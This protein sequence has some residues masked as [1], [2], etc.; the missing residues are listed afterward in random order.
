MSKGQSDDLSERELE[1]LRL[2]ATGA[3]N[4]EIAQALFISANT[5][6]VHLRNIF[7]K[8]GA[9]SRT[10]AAMYAVRLGL[11]D[12][13][14]DRSM[15]DLTKPEVLPAVE[16]LEK[17]DQFPLVES[18]GEVTTN[19]T[20][21]ISI[22]NRWGGDFRVSRLSIGLFGLLILIVV[23][24]FT[25]RKSFP[26]LESATVTIASTPTETPL[27]APAVSR[28]TLLAPEPFQRQKQA[29]AA[30]NNAVYLIGGEIGGK[31]VG[32]VGLYQVAG[33]NWST[34][35]DNPLPVEDIRAVVVDGLLVVPG[36][37]TEAG[38]ITS[39]VE[40]YNPAFDGWKQA[41]NL[42]EPRSEYALAAWE[43][44][45]YLFGGWDGTNYTNTVFR[46]DLTADAWTELTPMPTARGL[47]GAVASEGKIYVY[48]GWNGKNGLAL[49]EVYQPAL[50][51]AGG[52]P[53]SIAAS[54]PEAHY[55]F[56]S[57]GIAFFAYAVGGAGNAEHAPPPAQYNIQEN[58]W[59]TF[60]PPQYDLGQQ[61]TMT[62]LG[63]NLHVFSDDQIHLS[64]EAVKIVVIPL[65]AP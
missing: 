43:G 50:E 10:E 41:A 4:K 34:L 27:V 64:Y 9:A 7:A 36:G 17:P 18:P 16:E 53:W 29:V 30:V 52:S 12:E 46:Y 8:I 33:D 3:S 15:D 28:W 6:K 55:A 21:P 62:I 58:R 23:L 37:R 2:I 5:V 51:N 39:V 49:N 38:L 20:I 24:L 25:L 35:T 47:M 26:L 14:A 32:T 48:G 11:T 60:S 54:M 45:V 63:T 42:P 19:E 1:I 31:V 13:S 57:A 61:T 40:I 65:I 22:E 44:R 56:G 59:V